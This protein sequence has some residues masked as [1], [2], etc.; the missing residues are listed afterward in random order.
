MLVLDTCA[1]IYDALSPASLSRKA[2][3]AIE[4][5]EEDG[6]LAC[7]DISLWEIAM[8][9]GKGRLDPGTDA[10]TF[11]RLLHTARQIGVVPI[12]PE[13]AATSANPSLFGHGDPADRI[14]AATAIIHK[15]ELV[16]CDG[17]LKAVKGLRVIW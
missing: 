7:S 13:I 3:K 8:L 6:L 15:A 11:L 10:V 16:T 5:G 12:T 14:I 17:H 4:K 2:V 1:L 9:I